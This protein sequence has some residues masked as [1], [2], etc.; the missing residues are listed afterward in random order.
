MLVGTF[1]TTLLNNFCMF[2]SFLQFLE[3]PDNQSLSVLTF[4]PSIDDDGKHLS[5]RAANPQIENSAIEDK[6]F[7]VVHCK[8]IISNRK[9]DKRKYYILKSEPTLFPNN[10]HR[11]QI[12]FSEGGF[13]SFLKHI[14]PR[15]YIQRD[16]RTICDW[17]FR[18]VSFN[19]RTIKVHKSSINGNISNFWVFWIQIT[20]YMFEK[21]TVIVQLN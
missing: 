16:L 4:T 12:N 6:W 14:V 3:N 19:L 13:C 9:K 15:C 20:I 21:R 2:A 7:L 17:I 11:A 1:V 10:E 8:Y 18:P 5:C